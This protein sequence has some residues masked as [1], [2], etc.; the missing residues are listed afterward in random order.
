[1][2]LHDKAESNLTA[3]R[4]ARHMIHLIVALMVCGLI[5]ATVTSPSARAEGRGGGRITFIFRYDDYSSRSPTAF[6]E[7]LI[8][9]F[10]AAKVPLTIAVIP[11]VVTGDWNDP[12]ATETLPLTEAKALVLRRAAGEGVVEVALHGL[13]HGRLTTAPDGESSEFYGVDAGEQCAR[14]TRGKEFLER[15]TG[16]AVSSFI[17]PNNRY[18]HNT[19][20]CLGAAAFSAMSAD[21]TGTADSSST[22]VRL[23][24]YVSEIPRVRKAVAAARANVAENPVIVLMMHPADFLDAGP[25]DDA[26]ISLREFAELVRWISSQEDI[27]VR[28]LAQ[29]ARERPDFD[30][31][32]LRDYES[33]VSSRFYRASPGV[34]RR[35]YWPPNFYPSRAMIARAERLSVPSVISFYTAVALA[36]LF[37]SVLIRALLTRLEPKLNLRP[38]FEVI[39]HGSLLAIGMR[40]HEN[41]ITVCF[42]LAALG[43]SILGWL[44]LRNYAPARGPRSTRNTEPFKR[45][46]ERASTGTS[47]PRVEEGPIY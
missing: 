22:T 13:T 43:A 34:L 30:G 45:E 4:L 26:Q 7:K 42:L 37:A 29:A 17:P 21:L 44:L 39:F 5:F 3:R 40:W 6:E 18:D 20:R 14:L 35:A 15:H 23:F 10:R 27:G 24:P 1:M 2:G 8:D 16:A 32:R 11:H 28:T 38:A 25:S 41:L 19:L 33:F 47:G 46:R 9:V 12:A 31:A 36:V